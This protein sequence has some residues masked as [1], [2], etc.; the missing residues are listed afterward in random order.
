MVFGRVRPRVAVFTTPNREFN[1]LFADFP[2]PFRHWDHRFEWTRSA[3]GKKE[4]QTQIPAKKSPHLRKRA[5]ILQ[6]ILFGFF[7]RAKL[8]F[9]F[10]NVIVLL[11]TSVPRAEFLSWARGI[12]SDYPDYR[13]EEPCPGVGVPEAGAPLAGGR[14]WSEGRHG[15]CSQMAVFVRR[16]FEEVA[17]RWEGEEEEQVREEGEEQVREEGE[18]EEEEEEEPAVAE[19]EYK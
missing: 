18:E 15:R 13:L 11:Y 16:D 14:E 19:E 8:A 2:G 1:P 9:T 6:Y 17:G 3:Q 5:Y 12:A 10:H 4:S 7:F